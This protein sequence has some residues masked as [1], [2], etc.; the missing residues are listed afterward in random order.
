VELETNVFVGDPADQI[1]KRAATQRADLIVVDRP[2][3]S[4]I[5]ERVSGPRSRRISTG[6]TCAVLAVRHR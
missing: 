5:R 1:P 3:R 6:A 2:D 4:T